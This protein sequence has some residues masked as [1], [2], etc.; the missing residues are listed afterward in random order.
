M[1]NFDVGHVLLKYISLTHIQKWFILTA[2]KRKRSA[3]ITIRKSVKISGENK[4][5]TNLVCYKYTI[6]VFKISFVMYI[7]TGKNST[8]TTNISFKHFLLEFENN[9]LGIRLL[10]FCSSWV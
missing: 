3:S 6:N 5:D 8:Y 2:E 10:A 7:V 9:F 1:Y 4:S